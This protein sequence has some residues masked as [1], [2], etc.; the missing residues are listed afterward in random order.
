MK[1]K[2]FFYGIIALVV[3][4]ALSVFTSCDSDM[5]DFSLNVKP[6]EGGGDNTEV[7]ITVTRDSENGI[8][9]ASKEVNGVVQDTTVVVPLG[10]VK[11]DISPLETIKVTK[12]EVSSV[13]FAET[14]SNS[15]NWEAEGVSYTKTV[16]T[17]R[18]Q[19]SGY[20]KD[21][22]ISYLD[23]EMTLWGKKVVFPAAN[24]SVSFSKDGGISVIDEGINDKVH[25]YLSTS[26]YKV[27]FMG[28]SSIEKGFERLAIDADDALVSTDKTGEGYETLS[29]TTAKSW[30]EITRTY[31]VSG[32]VVSK[33]E[34]ILK[35]GISAPAYEIRAVEDFD[36]EKKNAD[37]GEATVTGTRNEGNITVTA[38]ARDYTV[39]CNLF[40]R[41]F[42][43]FWETAVLAVDGKTFEMPSRT[44][45]NITDKGFKLTEMP[46][47]DDYERRLYTHTM[48]AT[49]NGN[50]A[51][52]IAEVELH[53]K[54]ED[55]L[56][57]RVI[58]EDGKD[59]VNPTTTKSW[60]K[61]KE[62]WSVSGEKV[63]TKSVNLTNGI[64]VPARVVKILENF[65]LNGAASELGDEVLT[66]TETVGDFTVRTYQRAFTVNNDKFNR[67]FALSYQRAFYN[68]MDH[69]M[70][71]A[72]YE[73]VSDKG[74]ATADITQ[75]TEE[76]K[77]Y[78]RK[79]YT[80]SMS[81]SFNGYP[82]DAT[83]EAELWVLADDVMTS[84]EIIEDGKDYVDDNT[85]K[86]W[87]KIKEIWTVGGE[88]VYTESIDLKNGISSPAKITKVLPSF[89]LT[90]AS[91]SLGGEKLVKTETL[92]N[93]KVM[94]YERNYTVANDKFNRIFTL[95]YQKAVYNPLTHEMPNAE[96]EN[97][98]DNGFALAD[99]TRITQD[100]KTYDRKSYTHNIGATFNGHDAAASGEAE[101]WV[102]LND[103]LQER[104]V[105]ED[106][107]DYVDPS[108]TKSWLKIREVWSI[109]GEKVYTKSVNLK[110]G[111]AAPAKI[112]KILENFNLTGSTPSASNEKMVKS[113][114][115]GDFKVMTYER[116]YT[117]ANDKFDRTFT[118]SYQ[119][120]VYNP[121]THDMPYA[122]YENLNDEGFKMTDL[123][124]IAADGKI[125]DRK[126][127]AHQM[128]AVFNG[129]PASATAPAELRVFSREDRDTP[130][131]LGAPK[132]AKYTR[133]QKAVG[134]KFM[135]MIVFTYENG[136]VMAP[137]GKV[138][139]N[140]CYAFDATVA[141]KNGVETC[142]KGSYSGVW[143]NN[144]WQPAK[145]TMTSG[146]WIY[147]GKNASWDHTVMEQNAVALNIGTDVTPIPSAQSY[148]INGN[149]ITVSYAVNN[150][151]NT[152]N[153]SLSLK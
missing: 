48:S 46:E 69:S 28:G 109:S 140:L 68:P 4:L 88:K 152:A 38:H 143:G 136:V 17:Y 127:Y 123:D 85:T 50:S 106:G 61:I 33:Y 12:P 134:Q 107:K 42:V 83:A 11:F 23:A 16:R 147:A 15:N 65:D 117:V 128:S 29:S 36:L 90:S 91:P 79:S 96:Y 24:G 9:V 126:N 64:T 20:L 137:N 80:H 89:N 119:K 59:Y 58:V 153:T 44:Y 93:F 113:E 81:A 3:M 60:I 54:A 99:L 39:G 62:I 67:V 104:T 52:A 10:A 2:S 94:T 151:S 132:S 70:P 7:T 138:D 122:E 55:R 47:T 72:L 108:T 139:M 142:L 105:L 112:T 103:Q 130:S 6:N 115:V 63:Y 146:R 135:D 110:N 30:V 78:D 141:A 129:Y 131:W 77:T 37:L 102:E 53:K 95:S 25:Y 51:Q 1:E 144:K 45:E 75:I 124:Q 40:D 18:H 150:G 125:Y 114:T 26:S 34:V 118:L 14:G 73:S 92:G 76:G 116:T 31:R 21:I 56:E 74:F 43:P 32:N 41:V 120:A 100:G 145:I 19:L 87:I 98:S 13:D 22:T 97:V 121:L 82:A 5:E 57:S 27:A 84:R 49:F 101:L 111:I 35:N 8:V 148:K 86:S 149:Q 66:Q 71:Y 133:V